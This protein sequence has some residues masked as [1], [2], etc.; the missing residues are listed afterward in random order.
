[1]T[2]DIATNTEPVARKEYHCQASDWITN[3][4]CDDDFTPEELIIF[5]KAQAEK[6]KILKGTQYRKV[7]GIWE[8]ESSVFRA[9]PDMDDIC[10]KYDIY[11]L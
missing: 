4:M 6:F 7:S 1:M 3:Y 2:W 11:D 10:Q 8:G 5:K 9:R